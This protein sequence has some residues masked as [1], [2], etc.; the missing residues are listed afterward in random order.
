MWCCS[1]VGS[2]S[3]GSGP[4]LRSLAEVEA[5][6]AALAAIRGTMVRPAIEAAVVLPLR[7]LAVKHLDPTLVADETLLRRYLL[8]IQNNKQGFFGVR[9]ES[10]SP[11]RNW[12]SAVYEL[13]QGLGREQLPCRQLGAIVATARAIFSEHAAEHDRRQRELLLLE[14]S[15]GSSNGD[16]RR[17][18]REA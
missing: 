5:D 8:S 18:Q 1:G 3:G 16:E 17:Q 4:A 2:G 10:R 15:D 9:P 12:H 14:S 11:V 7:D 6:E 13:R